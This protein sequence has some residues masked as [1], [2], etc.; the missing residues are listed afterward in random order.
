MKIL[1]IDV[2][3]TDIGG[4]P[5]DTDDGSLLAEPVEI[6]TP[7]PATPDAI[8]GVVA[9]IVHRFDWDGP[10]GVAFPAVISECVVQTAVNVDES[11]VG[12]NAAE[13]FEE[14]TGQ[15]VAVLNDADAAGLAEMVFGAGRGR[16]GKAV[17][18]TI[19]T[20]LGIAVFE[21]GIL[22]PNVEF[23]DIEVRGEK[24]E[25]Q[26]SGRAINE[27]ELEWEAFGERLDEYLTEVQE[28]TGAT[29]FILGGGVSEEHDQ[30][31]QYLHVGAE[32][33]PA[34]MRNQAGVVGAAL[35]ARGF[36]AEG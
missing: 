25:K 12:V 21:D 15:P 8:A 23:P 34:E 33:V 35:A 13:T 19:G 31:M 26:A 29:L 11:W 24:A 32:I 3:A 18:I 27:L 10:I 2:G 14:A 17:I 28:R 6:D 22:V 9:E 4:A 30:F 7:D 20:G 36:G 5:V 16:G 1:G